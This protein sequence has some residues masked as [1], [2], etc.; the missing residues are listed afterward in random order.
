M[1][2]VFSSSER[3]S[4]AGELAFSEERVD[5]RLALERRQRL[6]LDRGRADAPAAPAGTQVEQL[7]PGEAD[8][9]ERRVLDPL[10]QVLDEL[11]QRILGPVDVL[12]D[13]DQRLRGRE[14]GGPLARRP[15]DLLLAPLRLDPLEHADREREQI[16][17]GVVA[18]GGLQ[19]RDGLL[20]R[21]RRP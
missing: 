3:R 19:L 16:G 7:G 17:D 9:Q 6:E 18:A 11:E 13:E 2:S 10:G 15:G 21:D 8:D 12:E 14:L 5:E 4:A 1:P 20:D